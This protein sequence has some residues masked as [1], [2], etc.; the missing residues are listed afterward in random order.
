MRTFSINFNQWSGAN[1]GGDRRRLGGNINAHWTFTNGWGIGT[2][3]NVMSTALATFVFVMT[4]PLCAAIATL[5]F[6]QVA[7]A[8]QAA[9]PAAAVKRR[10]EDSPVADRLTRF[11]R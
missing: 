8:N 10:D 1:F 4:M 7:P 9:R 11:R 2:G 6:D 5:V 3:F